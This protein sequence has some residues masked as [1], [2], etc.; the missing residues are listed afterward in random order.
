VSL[1]PEIQRAEGLANHALYLKAESR[2]ASG[3][4][5]SYRP[6]F[7]LEQTPNPESRVFL[8][9][10][11]DALSM[12]RLV[13]DWRMSPVDHA[14]LEAMQVRLGNA[15]VAAGLGT[16]D[17]LARPVSHEETHDGAHHM[18]T[19]R[20]G[21]DPSSGVVDK[22]CRVFGT[23][24]LYVASSSVFPTAG[25]YSPTFTILALAR[26]LGHHLSEG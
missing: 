25:A 26:R 8:G 5:S 13:V 11:V 10:E 19:T 18:G 7:E 15:C 1:S 3:R 6:Q 12:P 17:F 2:D 20:M 16:P 21:V 24:N 9:S 14:M 22:E 23:D 4:P